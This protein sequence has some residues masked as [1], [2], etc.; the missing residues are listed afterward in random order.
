MNQVS[1][2]TSLAFQFVKVVIRELINF[3]IA[4]VVAFAFISLAV[5]VVGYIIPKKFTSTSV[6]YA[7]QQNIIRPLLEG[8]ASVTKVQDKTRTVREV[9]TSPRILAMVVDQLQLVGPDATPVERDAV[10]KEL[11]TRLK[12]S[13]AGPGFIRITYT[14][15]TAGRTYDVITKV[16]DL[17]IKD[18]KDS[19]RS[20]SREAYLFIDKQ[21]KSYKSQL[22][23][24][25]EKLKA[26]KSRS[27][28]DSEAAVRSK[29]TSLRTKIEDMKLDI[30][31]TQTRIASL[32]QALR[33]ESRYV[34][35]QYKSDVFRE[36]LAI[37]Q[38]QLDTLLL[39]YKEDYPDVVALKHQIEDIKQQIQEIESDR[40]KAPSG[41]SSEAAF[42]PLYEELRSKLADEKVN[43]RT[44]IKRLE[45][46]KV[47]LEQE[48]ER[49]NRIA[50][51]QAELA[52]LTRDYNVTKSIYEDMLER[53]E[54]ARLSMTLDVEGQGVTY[55]IQEPAVFPL[56]PTGVRFLHFFLVGPILGLLVPIAAIVAFVQLDPRIRFVETIEREFSVPVL[57]VIPHVNTPL[58]SRLLRKDVIIIAVILLMVFSVYVGV[59]A[60]KMTGAL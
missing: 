27:V 42:N 23:E 8:K 6:I 10:I 29:I 17:F 22:Q 34:A 15:S 28:E 59:A 25:E 12:V 30:E 14:D 20:E 50:A 47:L 43:L 38:K 5:L 32:Q 1:N 57:A 60:A 40:E 51:D 4:V 35:K 9:I 7:D 26:F 44:K 52:E 31:E 39:S 53:K 16:I 48:T 55:K 45:S 2:P 37:A 46:T 36:R 24:A 41:A 49:L 3:R 21:V 54:K 11:R 13:S 58:S 18:S 56:T 19:K 33:K